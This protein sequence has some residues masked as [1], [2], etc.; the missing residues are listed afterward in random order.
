ME[1]HA[2]ILVSP[3]D[4]FF[5]LVWTLSEKLCCSTGSTDAITRS[6]SITSIVVGGEKCPGTHPV[7]VLMTPHLDLDFSHI[8]YVF[9]LCIGS[10]TVY[11]Q[12]Q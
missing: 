2:H 1:D 7:R 6:R 4:A 10:E 3:M 5:L 11:G 12:Q 8:S 9:I